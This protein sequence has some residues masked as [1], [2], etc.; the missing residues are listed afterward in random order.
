MSVI[1]GVDPHKASHTAVAIGG[2][3]R[4]MAK[5]TVRATC[6]QTPKL[7]GMGRALRRAHL[8]HRVRRW[9]RLSAG[10]TARRCRRSGARRPTHVGLEGQGARHGAF[11]EERS[12]RCLLRCHRR[13]ALEWSSQRSSGPITPRSCGCWPSATT[14]WAECGPSSSAACTTPWPSS[15]RAE[16][17]RN[18]T[19]LT[20]MRLLDSF[21]PATPIEHMRHQLALELVD[22]VAASTTRSKSH[23]AGSALPCGHRRPRSLICWCWPGPCLLADRLHR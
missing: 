8:G 23:T 4:E 1:I 11:G 13:L 5:V 22:D 18:S 12:Q 19:F 6:Q 16:L 10:P 9:S 3:E 7:L 15:H 20:P 2:D 17:P 14:T 21:E